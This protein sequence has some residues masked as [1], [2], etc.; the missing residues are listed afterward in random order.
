MKS[1]LLLLL[2]AA[3]LIACNESDL[4]AVCGV[5]NPIE[6]L[7][8]LKQEIENASIPNSSEYSFLM[9]AT[10]RGQTVFYFGF[11][12]PLWNWATILRDCQGNQIPG[13]V[14]L[15]DL[16]NEKVIWKPANSVCTFS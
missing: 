3:F 4:P 10:Y 1:F 11:C 13:E 16:V 7:A 14:S 5:E 2:S 6:D 12:N 15:T 9:Q 8:W